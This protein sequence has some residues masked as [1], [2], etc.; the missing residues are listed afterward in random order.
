V[1]EISVVIPTL[2]RPDLLRRVL[3][4]LG[5]QTAPPESFEVLVAAD[6]QEQQLDALRD[7]AR[8][9][10]YAARVLQQP[11]REPGAHD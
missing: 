5:R 3:D 4:R 7:A 6:E 8:G 2:G 10:P 11:A 1:S 9:Q